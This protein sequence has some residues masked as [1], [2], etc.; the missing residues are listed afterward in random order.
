MRI[1]ETVWIPLSDGCRLAARLWL[2]DE[3]SPVPAILEY[4]PYRRRDRHRG[5]DAVLHPGLAGCGYAA[6][7]VD[8]RGAGDSDGL[9]NDEYTPQEWRDA[10]EVIAWI[11]AQD[12]CSGSV[13]LIGISWSGFNALQIAALRPPALKAIVTACSTDD[14]YADDM[15]YMGGALLND[16]LQYGATLF[17]WT[18]TPPDPAIV[19]DR[20]KA[21]WLARLNAMDLPPAARWMQHPQRDDYWR[22][23]SVCEDYGRITVPVLAVGGWADGYTNT[24]LRLLE[25]LRGPRKGL[26][27]PWGHAFPHIATPGPRIDFI[28][29]VQRWFDQWLKGRETG[30]MAEPMLTYWQQRPEPPRARYVQ[31]QGHWAAERRWPSADVRAHTLH[32]APGRLQDTPAQFTATLSSP[33]TTGLASGE[34]CPYGWGPDMPGDQRE[35]DAG[36]LCFDGPPTA[37]ALQL[38]GRAEVRLELC[39]DNPLAMLAVRLN[40]VAPDG[41]AIRVSYGLLNLAARNGFHRAEPLVPGHYYQINV[42]LKAAAFVLPPGYR[43][44]VALSTCY[45]PLA[46]PLPVRPVLTVQRG[47]VILPLRDPDAEVCPPPALGDPWSPPPVPARVLVAPARGRQRVIRDMDDGETT[48]EVVRN[49]G[50]VELAETGLRLEA[51]GREIYRVNAHDPAGARSEAWRSAGFHRGDWQ[52]RLEIHS[53]LTADAGGWRLESTLDAW[54]GEEPCF[55]R[56]WRLDFPFFSPSGDEP[57]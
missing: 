37:T 38:L 9:M 18:P 54:D 49:L 23:G 51:L 12:W 1:I 13:G 36:S 40:A 39:A 46:A 27:G 44:R 48:L 8:M 19:G 11:A 32:L 43:L 15:H 4:L 41:T 2:P 33:A 56:R 7:R 47:S 35:D 17:T 29:Y 24:V 30:I 25:N 31:R 3:S 55:S 28:G 26:I 5:D 45:W 6:L 22:S 53:L 16:N 34:W 14:R 52:A 21:M 20:W 10:C 42:L 57:A 50:A